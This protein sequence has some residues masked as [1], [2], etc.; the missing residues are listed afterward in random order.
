MIVS[1]TTTINNVVW[2][3]ILSIVSGIMFPYYQFHFQCLEHSRF[4][5]GMSNCHEWY[6]KKHK[7]NF[8]VELNKRENPGGRKRFNRGLGKEGELKNESWIHLFL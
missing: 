1:V 2:S 3:V 4:S 7:Q 5:V 8:E 6:E